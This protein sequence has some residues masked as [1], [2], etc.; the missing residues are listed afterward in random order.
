MV[1]AADRLLANTQAEADE[2]VSL[3]DADPTRVAV[4]PPGV[5][6]SVFTPGGAQESRQRLGIPHDAAMLLFVGR[7][8]PLKAPDVLLRAAAEMVSRDPDA[9]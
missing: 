8:Q 6:L 3:Y 9:S 5:D 7:I 4:V 1:D 2:L